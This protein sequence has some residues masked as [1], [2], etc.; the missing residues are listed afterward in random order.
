MLSDD[1]PISMI[2][3]VVG[4]RRSSYYYRAVERD[5]RSLTGALETAAAKFPTY[6]SRRLTEQIKRDAP[7]LKPVGRWARA[8]SDA[9][10]A[11]HGA[12]QKTGSLVFSVKQHK[13]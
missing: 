1:Y 9:R 3:E 4:L 11:S 10:N 8:A 7:E 6:G 2:C 13:I 5:E 12:P